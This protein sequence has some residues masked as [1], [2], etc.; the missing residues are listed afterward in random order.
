MLNSIYIYKCCIPR[1]YILQGEK[2]VVAHAVSDRFEFF[3]MPLQVED[4]STVIFLQY[5]S[6]ILFFPPPFFQQM[7]YVAGW[8]VCYYPAGDNII[9]TYLLL[10]VC[11]EWCLLGPHWSNNLTQCSWITHS[12]RR[13]VKHYQLKRWVNKRA[14]CPSL[15]LLLLRRWQHTSIVLTQGSILLSSNSVF[16]AY[17]NI[18]YWRMI[19]EAR[20]WPHISQFR[21]L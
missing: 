5:F 10:R 7:Q 17:S 9:T 18:V 19:F 15:S 1:L 21:H 20:Q 13:E 2:C 4:I 3:N 11:K 16:E 12:C 6:V 14:L 8:I